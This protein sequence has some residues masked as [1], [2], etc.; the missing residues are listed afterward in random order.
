M[1]IAAFRKETCSK[2]G[3]ALYILFPKY[4]T[5]SKTISCL[6]TYIIY[7][8]RLCLLKFS[9]KKI[10]HS[11]V[12]KKNQKILS[13]HWW[14]VDEGVRYVVDDVSGFIWVWG[15]LSTHQGTLELNYATTEKLWNRP[16]VFIPFFYSFLQIY[17]KLTP[18]G[19]TE[20]Q[21]ETNL[22]QSSLGGASLQ[23]S[24]KPSTWTRT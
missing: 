19:G 21:I 14:Y 16:L 23:Q 22:Y 18:N 12:G 20:Q 3:H 8:Q 7:L 6:N 11:C 10:Q 4:S 1:S 5:F 13:I 2:D 15:S 17:T 24:E 9:C